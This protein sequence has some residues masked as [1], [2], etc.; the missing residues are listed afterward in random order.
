MRQERK[1]WSLDKC[2]KLGLHIYKLA[3]GQPTEWPSSISYSEE[4]DTWLADFAV[5]IKGDDEFKDAKM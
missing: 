4:D 3:S 1:K 5:K 2:K